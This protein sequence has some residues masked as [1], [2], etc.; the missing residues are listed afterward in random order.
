[1]SWKPLL[2][3]RDEQCQTPQDDLHFCL[4][5]PV[6]NKKRRPKKKECI[7]SV[8]DH[9]KESAKKKRKRRE[10]LFCKIC[11][12]FNHNTKDC[13]KN[14]TNQ[15]KLMMDSGDV[16]EGG[17]V[18]V[19]MAWTMRCV[20]GSNPLFATY[21]VC[22]IW[23]G[24]KVMCVIWRDDFYHVYLFKIVFLW[25]DMLIIGH[26]GVIFYPTK[27]ES[28]LSCQNHALWRVQYSN[29][30]VGMCDRLNIKT[31]QSDIIIL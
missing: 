11:H 10:K 14:P 12:T 19:G 16:G 2:H 5:W 21:L 29:S 30:K 28:A 7:K 8:M 31:L 9:I 27:F 24:K 3:D 22:D 23:T 25:C 6:A 4:A 1:M 15:S 18:Q 17:D 20:G 13:W 26:L